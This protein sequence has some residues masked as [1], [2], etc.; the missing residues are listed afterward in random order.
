MKQL[1]ARRLFLVLV[2]ALAGL[3]SELALGDQLVEHW[4]RLEERIVGLEASVSFGDALL[5]VK[6]DVVA[7]LERTHRVSGTELH[8][9]VDVAGCCFAA[10]KK[11]NF[12]KQKLE[13][14]GCSTHFQHPDGFAHV[15]N[16]QTVNNEPGC[17]F[18]R[19]RRLFQI[20]S[21][22]HRGGISGVA[23]LG[24]SDDFQQLHHLKG[25]KR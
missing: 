6:P 20:L 1:L 4:H 7:E 8:G 21:E 3:H 22:L 14:C 25:T 18:T 2:P 5:C 10:L 15:R 16:Q 17:V 12:K 11:A 9:N 13:V 19:D 24:G 23:C